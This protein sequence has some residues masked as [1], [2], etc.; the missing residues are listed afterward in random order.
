MHRE[1]RVLML[2]DVEED[3]W[4]IERALKKDKMFFT[5]TRVDTRDEFTAALDNFR[6]DVILSDHSLPQF[7]SI[8]ALEICRKNKREIPFLL[9][10]GAVSEEFA[11]TCLKKGADDYVLKSNLSR[12]P[13]AIQHAIRQRHYEASR[14][15]QQVTLRNQNEELKKLN[16]ELDLFVYSTS[17]NLRAPL[18]SVLGLINLSKHELSNN[19]GQALHQFFGMMEGSIAQLDDTLKLIL[20][21]SRSS[22]LE[23]EV[24]EIDFNGIFQSIFSGLKYINGPERILKVINIKSGPAFYCNKM[25][26]NLVLLNLISNSIKY[27]DATKEQSFIKMEVF[28]SEL[29]VRIEIEDNGIG[30]S[31]ELQSHVFDMFYRATEKAEGSG[32]G[33]YIVKETLERLQGSVSLISTAGAGTTFVLTIPNYKSKMNRVEANTNSIEA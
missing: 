13:L 16:R 11:V 17:H 32:L 9:V 26:L 28:P 8:E 29:D 31:E 20:E 27:F 10:T 1:L 23:E 25:R 30:I 3:A 22:R 18:R 33:L 14:K 4:L 19:N 6:P 2:E 7:N 21:Y 24:D 5:S 12:L 15:K